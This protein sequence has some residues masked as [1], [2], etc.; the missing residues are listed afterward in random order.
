MK[1][2]QFGDF[3]ESAAKAIDDL[4]LRFS[5]GQSQSYDFA[6]CQRPD[7]SFYGTGGQ[8]RTGTEAGAKEAPER[9][10]RARKAAKKMAEMTTEERRKAL[11]QKVRAEVKDLRGKSP[12]ELRKLWMQEYNSGRFPR[13]FPSQL[14]M[15]K[16]VAA[17]RVKKDRALVEKRA[18]QEKGPLGPR[19]V[20]IARDIIK[21][22]ADKNKDSQVKAGFDLL[23]AA[24]KEMNKE[25]RVAQQRAQQLQTAEARIFRAKQ[26]LKNRANKMDRGFEKDDPKVRARLAKLE[27]AEQK[28]QKLRNDNI[29]FRK[30]AEGPLRKQ[31][32]DVNE[33]LERLASEIRR[34]EGPARKQQL[35]NIQSLV[36]S[37][38]MVRKRLNEG[39]GFAP[40]LGGKGGE[41]INVS[42]L[43]DKLN[44]D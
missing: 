30:E 13:S 9:K 2:K 42:K 40:D 14:A 39:P 31:L 1:L 7:G 16:D 26:D 15:A 6:R 28:V 37:A 43:Y 33:R 34:Q 44:I 36:S 41:P 35:D 11:E 12:E 4:H 19:T 10:P 18:Q 38:Q 3:S 24:N 5:E 8:C 20:E 23:G 29:R 21:Q 17:E 25:I 22:G 27:Q 32:A